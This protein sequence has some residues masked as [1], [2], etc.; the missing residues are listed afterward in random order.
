MSLPEKYLARIGAK[1]T[2][3]DRRRLW[4]R[5]DRELVLWERPD[6]DTET[7][8]LSKGERNARWRFADLVTGSPP[9]PAVDPITAIRDALD[10]TC[11]HIAE[12][13]TR[14]QFDDF[15]TQSRLTEIANRWRQS[16]FFRN[17]ALAQVQ[18]AHT[19]LGAAADCAANLL[20][21]VCQDEKAS[22]AVRVKAAQVVLGAIGIVAG[23]KI[24]DQAEGKQKQ[25][26]DKGR[27]V[28]GNVIQLKQPSTGTDGAA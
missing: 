8:S 20:V 1:K 17:L 12:Y 6:G 3:F 21:S 27:N 16:P 5:E 18:A 19:R 23:S 25:L 2:P 9:R 14:E 7:P 15:W 28:L 11:G 13:E 26:R 10:L 24:E 22:K 4:S